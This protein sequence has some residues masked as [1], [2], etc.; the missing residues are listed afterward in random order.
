MIATI[1]DVFKRKTDYNK[2]LDIYQNGEDN[3]YPEKV[4]RLVNNSVTAKMA[5]NY[6]IQYLIGKGFGNSD[7][8]IIND[9]TNQKLKDFAFDLADDIAKN[10]GFF[11]HFSYDLNFSPVNPRV[12]AFENC[13]VGQKDS[14][15]YNGKIIYKRD[16][17]NSKE[18]SKIFDVYN[19]KEE[20]VKYQIEASGGIEKYKGQ[21]LFFNMDRNYHYPLSRFDSVLNDLR[22]EDLASIYRANLLEH[23]FFGKTLVITPP[24]IDTTLQETI[25]DNEGR[26]IPSPEYLKAN[27]EREETKKSIEDFLG[28]KNAGGAILF[29]MQNAGDKIEDNL[30]IKQIES[31][32]DDKMFEYTEK[33]VRS[34]ILMA[35]NNLPEDL[36]SSSDNSLFGQNGEAI[37][38]MQ[39]TYWTN[40]TYERDL[41]Q[42]TVNDVLKDIYNYSGEYLF[43]KSLF[44]EENKTNAIT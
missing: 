35:A 7:D 29:E 8:F 26:A 19:K 25:Y 36:V 5:L 31:K 30:F 15:E 28:A 18:E 44:E 22:S 20:V 13:R 41:L 9:H 40:T 3:M 1:L 16:W 21:V 33:K 6:M 10:R 38:Q 27:S 24:L 23:G 17:N 39:K 32:I 4:D 11:I 42:T 34:N 2:K 12:L 14:E 43:I 37:K